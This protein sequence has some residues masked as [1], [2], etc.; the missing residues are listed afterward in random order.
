LK[1]FER[2]LGVLGEVID[3]APNETPAAD[4][5]RLRAAAPLRGSSVGRQRFLSR[6]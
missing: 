2:T 4:A 1:Q 6:L 5:G 3:M